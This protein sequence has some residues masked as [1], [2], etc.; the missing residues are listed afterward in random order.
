M[1]SGEQALFEII[2]LVVMIERNG[3]E[4]QDLERLRLRLA[5]EHGID[6]VI[7]DRTLQTHGVQINGFDVWLSA[8]GTVVVVGFEGWHEDF[9][10][11]NEALRCYASGALG[12]VRLR[13]DRRGTSDYRWRAET[14]VE[15]DWQ[16]VSEVGLIIYPFWRRHTFRYLQNGNPSADSS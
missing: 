14:L 1:F 2:E 5:Q 15:G 11:E 9:V 8:H 3:R 16:I 4:L 13:V 7:E 6:A 10:D 12:R